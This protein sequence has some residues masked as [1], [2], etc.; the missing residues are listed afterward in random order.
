MIHASMTLLLGKLHL[1]YL[2]LHRFIERSGIIEMQIMKQFK[3]Q[4]QVLIGK[5][6]SKIRILTLKLK[7]LLKR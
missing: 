1:G 5:N 6:L 2:S 7:F 3:D 4:E